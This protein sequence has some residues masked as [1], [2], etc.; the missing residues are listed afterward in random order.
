MGCVL[1]AAALVIHNLKGQNAQNGLLKGSSLAFWESIACGI[2]KM[3]L[4]N[5]L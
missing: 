4:V 2:L 5:L 1:C 3:H